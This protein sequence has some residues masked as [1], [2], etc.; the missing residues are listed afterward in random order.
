MVFPVFVS[1]PCSGHENGI[2]AGW[3]GVKVGIDSLSYLAFHSHA[4]KI[5]K[6][7]HFHGHSGV[8]EQEN[9]A[10]LGSKLHE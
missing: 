8:T 7:K 1:H 9:S 10:S 2:K 3:V 5:E 6:W 4:Y